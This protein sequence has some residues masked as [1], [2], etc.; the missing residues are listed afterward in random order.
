MS[1][2]ANTPLRARF[3]TG[4]HDDAAVDGNPRFYGKV[5]SRADTDTGNDE[6]SFENAT[7]L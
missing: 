1:P 5:N 7:T 2:A 4:I 6:V 3:K